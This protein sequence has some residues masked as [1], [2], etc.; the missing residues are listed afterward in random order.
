MTILAR[1]AAD[2]TRARVR[3]TYAREGFLTQPAVFNR[4]S[5]RNIHWISR[6]AL[7]RLEPISLAD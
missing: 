1:P 3:R 5:A 7:S 2:V 6:Y 4:R